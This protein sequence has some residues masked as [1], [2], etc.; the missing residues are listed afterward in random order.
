MMQ[1]VTALRAALKEWFIWLG[2]TKAR[3]T[4]VELVADFFVAVS[5]W[6]LYAIFD[7]IAIRLIDDQVVHNVAHSVHAC[8][9]I[10]TFSSLAGLGLL[11]IVFEAQHLDA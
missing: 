8:A 7:Q 3:S 11:R 5:L 6:V 4:V 2:W 1:V 10:A 9:A